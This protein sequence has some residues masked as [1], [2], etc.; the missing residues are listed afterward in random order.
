[1][2]DEKGSAFGDELIASL[3]GF[4]DHV[5]AGKP[6]SA[7]Y[8]VRTVVFDLEPHEYTPEEVKEVRRK[9]G[10]SQAL[11]AKFLGV[12]VK[13]LQAWEQGVHPMPAIA[14]RF[15]DEIQATPEIWNR[16]IQVAAK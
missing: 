4:L 2:T 16:R 14:A 11:F 13:T 8:T 6:A 9:L 3:E 7:R 15:M 10:A 1:M 5:E 12:S